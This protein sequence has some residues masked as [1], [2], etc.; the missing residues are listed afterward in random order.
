M[1]MILRP[2][3]ALGLRGSPRGSNLAA[4]LCATMVSV[5]EDAAVFI[6]RLLD[7]LSINPRLLDGLSI[8]PRLLD[9]LSINPRLVAKLSVEAARSMGPGDCF[10]QPRHAGEIRESTKR[11][12]E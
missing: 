2:L 4:R 10:G 7:G 6:L 3:T 11:H 5:S 9:G 8:N 12:K 1:L